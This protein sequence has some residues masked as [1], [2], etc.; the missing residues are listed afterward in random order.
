MPR[1]NP[2]VAPDPENAPVAQRVPVTPRVVTIDPVSRI[3]GHLK[4]EVD[5]A[6]ANGAWVVTD[7]W[8][9]GTM[10][11][12]VEMILVNRDPW[13]AI[14]ITQRVCGVCPVS[15]GQ[16]AALA[17]DQ[18]MSA[19]PPNNGRLM[20]NLVLGANFVHNHILHFYHLAALDFFDGPAMAPWEPAWHS[21]KR[22][23]PATAAVLTD[24]YVAALEMRRRAHEM[25]ALFGG[26][27]PHP[28]AYIAGG[29]T[30]VPTAGE[31]AEF[32][33]TL[34]DLVAFVNNVYVPDINLIAAAYDDYYEIGVGCG[35]L[36]AY[37]AFE[38][39]G[40]GA[41]LLPRGRVENL[42]ETVLP[43]D[44]SAIAEDV[45][46]SW[47]ADSSSGLPPTSGQTVAQFPK[48]GAYSWLKA[49]RYAGAAYEAGPLSRMWV[50]GD[51][52][53]GASVMDRHM[54]RA[55]ETIKLA[56]AMDGWLNELV[57]GGP[58]F[59]ERTMPTAGTG[60][61]LT[62]APRG[63]LGHWLQYSNTRI[64]RYQ[65]V[66]PTCWNASPRDD[67]GIAG[68]IEQALVGTPVLDWQEPIEVLRVI[69]SFDPC[70]SC[71]VHV[72]RVDDRPENGRT[73][74]TRWAPRAGV[75]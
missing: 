32:R 69:H 36:L 33:A 64:T 51:Y 16:A 4:I 55:V 26:R 53:R 65:I 67:Q 73:I 3:E 42:S 2:P 50:S 45:S 22:L 63:A 18:A 5:L 71:A 60:I 43:V 57:P 28:P 20:R 56:Q 7:A 49:P 37:G 27:M 12:G 30:K 14:P 74:Q 44:T 39:A 10:F 34:D 23:D 6:P 15:H 24:H 25:G 66:T 58:V 62:E 61:G 13:D 29:F 46:S 72:A 70:L 38:L 11:R 47:Y 59:A 54:A 75:R 68:P 48:D 31:I 19:T 8:S 41:R 21:D 52:R 17:L 1:R 9:T 40:A 35:N